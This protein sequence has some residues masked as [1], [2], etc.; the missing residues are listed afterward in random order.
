MQAAMSLS[1]SVPSST[2]E[3]KRPCEALLWELTYLRVFLYVFC[4]YLFL[5]ICVLQC[6]S[7][8]T[9]EREN[10]KLSTESPN[11]SRDSKAR[12]KEDSVT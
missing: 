6:L 10:K 3:A 7:A 9:K 2:K 12:K 1:K 11:T 4:I 8:Q 5:C